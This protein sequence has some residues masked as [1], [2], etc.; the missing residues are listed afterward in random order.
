M[1]L[2]C[3][4][5]SVLRGWAGPDADRNPAS[6]CT[7]AV[8]NKFCSCISSLLD[9]FSVLSLSWSHSLIS[10]LDVFLQC[11]DPFKEDD[12]VVLNGSKEEV[13][14]L[15][16]DLEERR[17]KAKSAK[18]K[19]SRDDSVWTFKGMWFLSAHI[20]HKRWTFLLSEIKEKQRSKGPQAG[21][22]DRY[23]T[24]QN[25]MTLRSNFAQSCS[26]RLWIVTSGPSESSVGKIHVT[27]IYIGLCNWRFHVKMWCKLMF[28]WPVWDQ[29]NPDSVL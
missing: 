5:S 8:S 29:T 20:L 25:H 12:V 22:C 17:A 9:R 27:V 15:Q 2:S 21:R 1:K 26:L 11:G 10:V 18:V 16:K 6:F 19:K 7:R 23:S 13:E 14:K 3:L 28:M 4:F 24:I